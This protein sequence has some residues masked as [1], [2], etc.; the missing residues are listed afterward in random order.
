MEDLRPAGASRGA[1]SPARHV[2]HDHVR[3]EQMERAVVAFD[4]L[5]SFAAARG[6]DDR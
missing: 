6:I 1:A 3:Q 4:E 2:G 5:Q